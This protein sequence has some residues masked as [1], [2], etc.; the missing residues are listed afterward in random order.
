[1]ID[2]NPNYNFIV[3]VITLDEDKLEIFANLNDLNEDID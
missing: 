3:A 1:M 2:V